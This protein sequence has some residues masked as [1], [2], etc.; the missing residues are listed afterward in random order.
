[1]ESGNSS[2]RT[3]LIPK[4][5]PIPR[6][7]TTK[8]ALSATRK[9]SITPGLGGK[10]PAWRRGCWSL[11]RARKVLCLKKV[12]RGK[13]GW[14]YGRIE[15][16]AQLP[17]GKGVWPAIWMLGTSYG[18]DQ[19][20]P[21]CGEIDILEYVG[22]EPDHIYAT[23][24]YGESREGHKKDMGRHITSSP[25]KDFHVYSIEWNS[26]KIDYFFDGFKYHTTRLDQAS[27]GEKNPFRQPFYLIL[28]FALGGSWGGEIDD[29]IFPQQYLID[30][31]RVYEEKPLDGGISPDSGAGA[32]IKKS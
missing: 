25:F 10:T 30:Y 2:G 15:V 14:K 27:A 12:P 1:M 13:A 9:A 31:V 28:N 23:I 17:K 26:E 3:N 24:H 32:G 4:D 19:D 29:S 20:W 7:G 21:M 8:P 11:R 18:N 22:K 6:S 16:R 5:C